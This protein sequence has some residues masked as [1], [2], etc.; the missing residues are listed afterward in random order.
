MFE[1]KKQN[2]KAKSKEEKE[3]IIKEYIK[4]CIDSH[5]IPII[6]SNEIYLGTTEIDIDV[7]SKITFLLE[8]AEIID[9]VTNYTF[10]LELDRSYESGDEQFV[11]FWKEIEE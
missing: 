11:L 7:I 3:N 4:S 5:K 2:L 10:K 1:I 9:S 8:Y 6:C